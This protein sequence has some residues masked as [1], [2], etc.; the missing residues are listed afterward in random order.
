MTSTWALSK[1]HQDLKIAEQWTAGRTGWGVTVALLDTGL[2]APWGLGR[3]DF[4]YRDARGAESQPWDSTGHGT[5]CGS[6]IASHAGGA[7]GIAPDAKLVSLR[8]LETGSSLADVESALTYIVSGRP[9]I[10]VVSCS[11]VLPELS[12]RLEELL[13]LLNNQ[14]RL[15]IGA[16]GNDA[17]VARP[18]PERSPHVLTVAAADDAGRPLAGTTTD[19][20]LD[21]VAPG[22]GL[23]VLGTVSGQ[24][25]TFGAS[26]AAAALVSGVAAL[27]LST[28]A[29]RA[30]RRAIAG[31]LEALVKSTARPLPGGGWR[32]GLGMIDPEGV[33]DAIE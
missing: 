14:G 1:H 27:A 19:A 33:I 11:F 13:R 20:W 12:P 6:L 3:A 15:V 5:A 30:A 17:T 16:A 9:D 22:L 10:D 4:E 21:V 23:P 18:F 31:Q 28:K 25:A 32:P 7:L 29:D 26:S 24:R 2:A 8:V